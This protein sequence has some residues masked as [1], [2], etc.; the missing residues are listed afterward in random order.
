MCSDRI[1]RTTWS[2]TTDSIPI[3]NTCIGCRFRLKSAQLY[4]P[5]ELNYAHISVEYTNTIYD[6]YTT[7]GTLCSKR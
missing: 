5:D 4:S 1:E 2:L 7:T 3:R 6:L